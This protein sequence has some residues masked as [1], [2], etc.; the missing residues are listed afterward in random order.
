MTRSKQQRAENSEAG[1]SA[2]ASKFKQKKKDYKDDCLTK[3]VAS[4]TKKR[5]FPAKRI[6]I[7]KMQPWGNQL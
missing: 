7:N 1:S 5:L 2:T 4:G 6:K 3:T